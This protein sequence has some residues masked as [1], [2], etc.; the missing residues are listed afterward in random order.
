MSL[1]V[2]S[3]TNNETRKFER[4]SAFARLEI[5]KQIKT[6]R[7]QLKATLFSYRCKN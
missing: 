7:H 2:N 3:R 1:E 6:L 5:K 4:R